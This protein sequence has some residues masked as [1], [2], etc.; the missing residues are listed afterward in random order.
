M[1]ALRIEGQ[2]GPEVL[3]LEDAED[4]TPGPGEVLVR[5][6]AAGLNR[7]DLLQCMGL[8][9]PPP[10]APQ[11]IPGLEY[12]GEIAA[13]GPRA[14][15]F[16]VGD[17]VMGIVAGG[18]FA[19][20]LVAHEREVMAIPRDLPFATA[21][22]IPEAFLTAWDA[23]VVQGGLAGAQHALIHAV[24]SGV[25]TAGCQVAA[26]LGANVVGT[27]RSADKLERCK[28][29]LHLHHG[30]ALPSGP[31]FADAVKAATGGRGADV[32][33][34]LAGGDYFPETIEAAAHR[35]RIILVGMMAGP[36]SEVSLGRVLQKRLCIQGTT[37]RSRPLEEK[38]EI[39]Q[40][41]EREILPL[42]ARGALKAIVDA[43]HPFT[44]AAAAFEKMSSNQ[45]FGKLVLEWR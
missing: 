36:A 23:M 1:R 33:L 20:K 39:A 43:V 27:S 18:A 15:R 12:A 41:F 44:E 40:R 21:A 10:D 2:G 14:R 28:K 9:P 22:A 5:V 31:T 3:K 45:S 16:Q 11:D 29:E 38:I 7:A 37:L 19:E 32:V 4:P 34:D 24:A 17:R 30:I 8:Y 35:G 42:F 26:A 25:G 6:R 13:A